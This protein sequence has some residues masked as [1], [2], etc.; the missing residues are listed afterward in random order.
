[1]LGKK[2]HILENNE[3]LLAKD[4]AQFE[5]FF[6]NQFN[7]NVQKAD[8]NTP[9][10]P[11]D[12]DPLLVDAQVIYMT[13]RAMQTMYAHGVGLHPCK[14]V[15]L[16]VDEVDDLIID[17]SPNDIYGVP[18]IKKSEV[19]LE[20]IK[21]LLEG[22]TN[23]PSHIDDVNT[24]KECKAHYKLSQRKVLGRDYDW[25][26][27]PNGRELFQKLNGKTNLYA[28]ALWL[29]ILRYQNDETYFPKYKSF[30][31]VQSM[32]HLINAYDCVV[33]LSGSLGSEAENEFL[34]KIYGAWS[35]IV[36]P[37]LNTCVLDSGRPVGK[38]VAKLINN[39]VKIYSTKKVK[40]ETIFLL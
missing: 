15:I 38:C 18:H 3:G 14:N 31:F 8:N 32:P 9:G 7:I 6:R 19:L 22:G 39:E 23:M 10:A 27:G 36:P 20:C 33:G 40:Y 11:L 5:D 4:F 35:Y 28:Y 17:K 37:F 34:Q 26:D 30:Y 25:K 2:V 1:M 12:K 29:E 21:S 24:W 16:I 13:S